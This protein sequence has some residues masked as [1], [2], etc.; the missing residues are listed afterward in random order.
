MFQSFN[1]IGYKT[2]LKTWLFR[3]SIRGEPQKRNAMA[4]EQLERMGLPTGH[5]IFRA[6]CRADRNSAWP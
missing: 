4:M 5:I 6:N 2:R 1:L 3:F